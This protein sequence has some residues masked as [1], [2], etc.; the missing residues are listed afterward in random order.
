MIQ[1]SNRR[2]LVN[3]LIRQ[4]DDVS[5]IETVFHWNHLIES[6]QALAVGSLHLFMHNCISPDLVYMIG[7]LHRLGDWMQ[8]STP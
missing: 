7:H 4:Y 8:M 3:D 1:I 5:V 2:G 6:P